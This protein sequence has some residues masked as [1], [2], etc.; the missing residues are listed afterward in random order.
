[1]GF[2]EKVTKEV[3]EF[4]LRVKQRLKL[5]GSPLPEEGR[6]M[7]REAK[8]CLARLEEKLPLHNGLTRRQQEGFNSCWRE[9]KTLALAFR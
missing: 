2:R 3:K 4:V 8:A 1:M 5:S 7:T 9:L 6:G